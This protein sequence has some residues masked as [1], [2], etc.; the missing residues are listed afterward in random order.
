VL[1]RLFTAPYAFY[2]LAQQWE[3][4]MQEILFLRITALIFTLL[5]GAMNLNWT[6]TMFKL[7][8]KRER[9]V[10]TRQKQRLLARIERGV[11]AEL[12]SS[13]HRSPQCASVHSSPTEATA[14]FEAEQR[15][16]ASTTNQ[17]PKSPPTSKVQSSK[18]KRH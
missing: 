11:Q 17:Q 7:Y 10:E 5:L 1:L 2:R 18:P 13:P 9:L 12:A 14:V 3:Q 4:F 6:W 8:R 16:L 15:A